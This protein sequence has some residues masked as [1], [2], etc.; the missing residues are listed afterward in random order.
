M[1]TFIHLAVLETK[2]FPFSNFLELLFDVYVEAGCWCNILFI[3]LIVARPTQTKFEWSYQRHMFV[4]RAYFCF[5][6]SH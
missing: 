3:K 1:S 6:P 4:Q 5:G 2:M